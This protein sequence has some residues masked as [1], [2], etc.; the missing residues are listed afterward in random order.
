M[1]LVSILTFL[2]VFVVIVLLLLA[3]GAGAS[4]QTKQALAALESALAT[5]KREWRDQIV[6]IRKQEL[7]SAIPMLHRW[8]LRME[9]APRLQRLLYQA[10]LKWTAGGL[11]LMSMLSFFVPAYLIHYRTGSLV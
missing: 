2:G 7:F 4:Q 11:I 8:L 3:S 1:M 6:D 5:D 10:D 9:L